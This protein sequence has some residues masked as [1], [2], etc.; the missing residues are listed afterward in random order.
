MRGLALFVA[1]YVAL[2]AVASPLFRLIGVPVM[3]W[4][5]LA[6]A[7]GATVLTIVLA[8]NGRWNVGLAAPPATALRELFAGALFAVLLVAIADGFVLVTTSLHHIWRGRFPWLELVAVYVPAAVHEELVFRGYFFQKLR[9]YHRLFAIGATSLIFA[10]MHMGNRGITA[11]AFLNLVFAGVLLALAYERHLRLWTPIGLH[12]A[13]NL[14]TGPVL[15]YDVSGF[16]PAAS[17]F[18]TRGSGP[19]WLTGAAFGIEGSVWAVAA[20]GV[21]IAVL[22]AVQRVGRKSAMRPSHIEKG[23]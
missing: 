11:I 17:L 8:E 6:A 1:S 15:G 7:I 12:L 22:V 23:A 4:A 16:I 19:P 10:A 2:V 5:W 18:A 20:E 13:W 21:G 3:P 9:T 14:M